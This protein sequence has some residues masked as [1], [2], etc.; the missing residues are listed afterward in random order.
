MAERGWSDRVGDVLPDA[1]EALEVV[2]HRAN[3]DQLVAA[4]AMLEAVWTTM[5]NQTNTDA[6]C[7]YLQSTITRIR[8]IEAGHPI[9]EH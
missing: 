3:G 2:T 8:Q 4:T 6:T 9:E 7:D 5:A 1:Q